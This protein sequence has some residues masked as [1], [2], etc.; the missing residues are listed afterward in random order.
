MPDSLPQEI[1][2]TIIDELK[3]Y[4]HDL[5]S[6]SLTCRS[7]FPQ[8]RVHLFT[9][10]ELS[11]NKR[12]QEFMVLRSSSPYDLSSYVRSLTI[13]FRRSDLTFQNLL[14]VI[15]CL[16]VHHITLERLNWGKLTED[17]QGAL[18][19][20]FPHLRSISFVH[21][22]FPDYQTICGFLGGFPEL[23]DVSLSDAH[24]RKPGDHMGY[25]RSSIRL[26]GLSIIG[27]PTS[28]HSLTSPLS[29]IS[30]KHLRSLRFTW[31]VLNDLP[32]V[33]SILLAAQG[34][35]KELILTQAPS[36]GE[37]DPGFVT[38]FPRELRIRDLDRLQV[39]MWDRNVWGGSPEFD[40]LDAWIDIFRCSAG[41]VPRDI[42]FHLCL[43]SGAVFENWEQ[44]LG[45]WSSLD[46]V[47]AT[48][49]GPFESL[50]LVIY[51][52]EMAEMMQFKGVIEDQ[53]PR[54]KQRGMLD[55]RCKSF[56]S[57]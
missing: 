2:D 44:G 48:E 28:I 1:V 20:S 16:T 36:Y 6:C 49:T 52:L 19:T 51:G 50:S 41:H 39:E 31:S 18:S 32:T 17:M 8:T 23:Q 9:S 53:L 57:R 25:E 34:S 21:V 35:L 54:L 3:D 47:L 24:V 5:K 56:L 46:E 42:S 27:A 4:T 43:S 7:F 13:N 45:A 12:C 10:I 26:A 22:K 40:L 55:V 30:L 33:Q 38:E 29:P 11:S 15:T 14:D 37:I